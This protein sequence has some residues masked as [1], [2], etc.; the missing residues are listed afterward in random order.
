MPAII[1]RWHERWWG[2]PPRIRQGLAA[3]LIGLAIAVTIAK[4]FTSPYGPPVTVLIAPRD[5]AIGQVVA[6]GDFAQARRPARLVP[7]DALLVEDRQRVTGRTVTAS[8]IAGSVATW[9]HLGD[10]GLV[11][12]L[13]DGRVGVPVP[14]SAL[15]GLQVG[16]WVTLVAHQHDGH[17]T[18]LASHALVVGNDGHQVW[19]AVDPVNGPRIAAAAATGRITAV[20][21]GR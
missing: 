17:A 20:V 19:L 2:L 1:D 5:L 9:R 13:P 7:H 15:P 8:L 12:V 18:E 6:A 21:H 3:A 11:E 4:L 14:A 16:T 10:L